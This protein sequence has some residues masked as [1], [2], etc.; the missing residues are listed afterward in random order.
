MCVYHA[1]REPAR[2]QF[3]NTIILNQ[4]F[5]DGTSGNHCPGDTLHSKVQLMLQ[6]PN[7][8]TLEV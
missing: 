4:V 8:V 7:L 5:D 2:N 6:R 3:W 1:I